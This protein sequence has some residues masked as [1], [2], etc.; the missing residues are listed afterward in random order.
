M[1]TQGK[2]ILSD[3][4]R[5]QNR[6]RILQAFRAHG[7]M[8]RTQLA[9]ATGLSAGTISNITTRLLSDGILR[10]T[11]AAPDAP[12]HGRPQ[13]QLG[14]EP[15]HASLVGGSL[16]FGRLTL[17]ASD[18][19]GGNEAAR[20]LDFST[21]GKTAEQIAL[22]IAAQIDRV[23]GGRRPDVVSFGVQGTTAKAR[24]RVLWSPILSDAGLDFPKH[25]AALTG[26]RVLIENDCAVITRALGH[27]QKP[28]VP[29]FGAV[30]MSYGIGM[31]LHVNGSLFG[32]QLSSGAEFGHL[33]YR[34]G[35]A[36]C[37]CGKKGCIE[38]Y[39]GDY[40]IWRAATGM[41][42]SLLPKSPI[43]NDM[44]NG[45]VARAQANDGPERAALAE[46]ARALG[47]GLAS[48]FA[49]F[50]PFPVTFVGPGSALIPVMEQ[51][52]RTT[53]RENFRFRQR[54]HLTFGIERDE[55]SLIEKGALIAAQ[56]PLDARAAF[57]D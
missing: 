31:G 10:A 4:V 28:K 50:D 49:L 14:L 33:P 32:G 21:E 15:G 46:A 38:A 30:L 35:G 34:P 48:L 9:K 12:R 20:A 23:A 45:I 47:V 29:T 42:E 57:G 26:A 27:R 54:P 39:A 24:D 17:R 2:T 25:L 36:Q 6:L 7:A 1:Q 22:D 41:S 8:S 43:S 5:K 16:T 52:L 37:R 18:Y 44:I 3:D 40:A 55:T 53:L 51:E 19:S 11:G 13:V 56:E